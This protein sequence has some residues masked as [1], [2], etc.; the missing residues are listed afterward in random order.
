MKKILFILI[1]AVI[2]FNCFGQENSNIIIPE[3]VIGRWYDVSQAIRENGTAACEFFSDSVIFYSLSRYYLENKNLLADALFAY[4]SGIRRLY[5]ISLKSF[6]YSDTDISHELLFELP[7]FNY[8]Y[9]NVANTF[10]NTE[11]TEAFLKII[12]FIDTDWNMLTVLI[13]V[14]GIETQLEILMKH[15]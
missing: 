11:H 1:F 2:L 15:R 4:F 7:N 9:N 12:V 6:I 5:P 8:V 3:D 14:Y 10:D 13:S